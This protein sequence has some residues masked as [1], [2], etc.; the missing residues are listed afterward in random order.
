[1]ACDNNSIQNDRAAWVPTQC[2]PIFHA[3]SVC[4]CCCS[5]IDGCNKK[6]DFCF[7]TPR[8]PEIIKTPNLEYSCSNDR[9]M[10]SE[11]TFSC[12][13]GDPEK[14]DLELVGSK[15]ATCKMRD[16]GAMWTPEQP[17]CKRIYKCPSENPPSP[18]TQSCTNGNLVQSTCTLSCPPTHRYIGPGGSRTCRQAGDR[19]FWDNDFGKCEAMCE[20]IPELSNG[21]HS[22]TNMNFIGSECTFQCNGGYTLNGASTKTCKTASTPRGAEWEASGLEPR[23]D[24]IC[25]ALG[26][27]ENGR[28]EC[29]GREIGETCETVCD[30]GYNLIGPSIRTCQS[31]INGWNGV[32]WDLEP[33]YCQPRCPEVKKVE[34]TVVS[35]SSST[36]LG[37]VCNFV[38]IQGYEMVGSPKTTC[39]LNVN[40]GSANWDQHEPSCQLLCNKGLYCSIV[41]LNSEKLQ[42]F[43]FPREFTMVVKAGKSKKSF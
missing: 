14:Y 29:T 43:D 15:S 10:G 11:C 8:C 37:S 26:E 24:P 20:M 23:C 33:A 9:E 36:D 30:E 31:D 17:Y 38:C 12:V 41:G 5:D 19:A 7:E 4:R 28:L 34:N 2:N 18:M 39:M 22:C 40:D 21:H 27:P 1:M 16:I 3:N 32:Q 13:D 25:D 42:N 35:C 6:D